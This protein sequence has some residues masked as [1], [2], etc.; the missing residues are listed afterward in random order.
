MPNK[1]KKKAARET[2][3]FHQMRDERDGLSVAPLPAQTQQR[4]DDDDEQY[5]PTT[6][7]LL[8]HLDPDIDI[9]NHDTSVLDRPAGKRSK[10]DDEDRYFRWQLKQELSEPNVKLDRMRSSE[11]R[12]VRSHGQVDRTA[13][14]FARLAKSVEFLIGLDLEG[15]END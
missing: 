9:E 2:L 11:I 7:A 1:K 8:I 12:H 10:R 5:N 3:L 15:K 4:N 13:D 6:G 14:E